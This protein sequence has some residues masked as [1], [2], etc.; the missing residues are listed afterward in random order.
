MPR[1]PVSHLENQET[2]LPLVGTDSSSEELGELGDDPGELREEIR[3][4][5]FNHISNTL[6]KLSV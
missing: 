5:K 2:Q 4:W 1:G 3:F 6:G